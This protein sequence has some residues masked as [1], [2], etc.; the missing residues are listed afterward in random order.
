ML[1][2]YICKRSQRPL[3]QQHYQDKAATKGRIQPW[4]QPIQ[5]E[6]YLSL[7]WG[8]TYSG[9]TECIFL[10]FVL[11]YLCSEMR[12]CSDNEINSSPSLMILII[13]LRYMN[14][15]WL[16]NDF[17]HYAIFFWF[18]FIENFVWCFQ[19]LAKLPTVK[20]SSYEWFAQFQDEMKLSLPLPLLP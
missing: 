2:R 3:H 4:N 12:W 13:A 9:N 14:S 5:Y 1:F 18:L 8:L 20:R 11:F 6:S 17:L 15:K 7:L 19:V 10:H 16:L